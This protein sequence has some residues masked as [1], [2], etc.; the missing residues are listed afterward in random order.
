[1]LLITLTM[2]GLWVCGTALLAITAFAVAVRELLV[3]RGP[4][5]ARVVLS[6]SAVGAGTAVGMANPVINK[7]AFRATAEEYRAAMLEDAKSAG[8]VGQTTGWLQERYGIP[9]EVRHDQ[10][11]GAVQHWQYTPG[12]WFIVH[13]EPVAFTV[14]NSVVTGAEV[15]VN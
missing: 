15:H 13:D 12:P 10:R 1:M 5:L 9:R 7:A 6:L 3:K 4:I 11:D 14:V 2:V 8:V